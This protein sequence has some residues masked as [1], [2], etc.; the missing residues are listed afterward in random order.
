MSAVC[1]Q[2]KKEKH[3]ADVRRRSSTIASD[4]RRRSRF[5]RISTIA[6]DRRQSSKGWATQIAF[7]FLR[8]LELEIYE[9]FRLLEYFVSFFAKGWQCTECQTTVV[10]PVLDDLKSLDLKDKV[11]R[12]SIS[13]KSKT[14]QLHKLMLVQRP[15]FGVKDFKINWEESIASS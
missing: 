12:I 15:M 11:L 1:D 10:N 2:K 13:N 9:P 8:D 14:L 6:V 4:F 5:S 3:L 7:V